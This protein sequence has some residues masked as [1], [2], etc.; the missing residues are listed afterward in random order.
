MGTQ[1]N[2]TGHPP[3]EGPSKTLLAT[4]I[5]QQADHAV[6]T[7]ICMGSSH[8]ASLNNIHRATDSSSDKTSH[9]GGCK[10]GAEVILHAD[11]F[12]AQFLEGIVGGQ[13]G[14]GH[15]DGTGGVGPHAAEERGEAFCAGHLYKTV[16]GMAVVSALRG[17]QGGVGLHADVHY[18]G[19]IT[20]P[21]ANE[22]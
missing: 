1:T 10:V 6:T 3:T 5:T 17:G 9:E 21:A 20:S 13:L 2:E 7:A 4:D 14:G 12:N 16:E 22:A 15:E 11:L 18:V 8:N 19:G